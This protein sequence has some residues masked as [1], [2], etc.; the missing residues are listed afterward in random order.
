M[1]YDKNKIKDLI[2]KHVPEKINANVM[3]ENIKIIKL[4]VQK[5]L[6]DNPKEKAKLLK[7]LDEEES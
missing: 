4:Q 7:L 5:Y 2:R 6:D 1:H 3:F